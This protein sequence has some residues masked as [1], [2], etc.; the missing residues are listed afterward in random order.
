MNI[1]AQNKTIE[2]GTDKKLH[3]QH[4]IIIK[5]VTILFEVEISITVYIINKL[6]GKYN[7]FINFEI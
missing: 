7:Y 1:S 5:L 6:C 4:T 2:M 3:R